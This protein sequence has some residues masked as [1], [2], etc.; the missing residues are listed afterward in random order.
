MKK[1]LILLCF[2]CLIGI[3][4]A[5]PGIKIIHDYQ[6]VCTAKSDY[7]YPHAQLTKNG[8]VHDVDITDYQLK[9]VHLGAEY[10]WCRYNFEGGHTITKF[11]EVI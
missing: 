4:S 3:A 10:E 11:E 2:F 7:P 9:E 6:G 1:I 8:I 5:H